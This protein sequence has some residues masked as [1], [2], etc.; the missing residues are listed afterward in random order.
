MHICFARKEKTKLFVNKIGS[1]SNGRKILSHLTRLKIK[2]KK[3]TGFIMQVLPFFSAILK[4]IIQRYNLKGEGGGE[5]VKL[6]FSFN[7][8]NF[9]PQKC[10]LSFFVSFCNCILATLLRSLPQTFL[11]SL[12]LSG[13][14]FLNI[15]QAMNFSL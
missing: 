2:K 7:D 5:L 13:F 12:N 10:F 4:K 14:I 1:S 3:K 15:T 8:P 11:L 6:H 9:L